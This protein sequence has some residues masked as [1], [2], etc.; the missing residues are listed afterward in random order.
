MSFRKLAV[1]DVADRLLR[2]LT[3]QLEVLA[4]PP[5]VGA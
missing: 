3:L 1:E 4:S 2:D 5:A